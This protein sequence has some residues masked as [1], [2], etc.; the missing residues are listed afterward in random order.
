[1]SKDTVVALRQP[2]GKDLLSAMLREGAQ[3]LIVEALQAEFEEFLSQFAGQRDEHERAAVVRNGFQPRRELLTGLGAVSVRVPKARSRTAESV[4][5]RSTLVPPYVRRAK[6]LDAALPRLYLHGVSTGDMREALASLVG[7]EAKGVSAPVVARLKR[8][9]NQEYQLWRRQKL[10]KDRWVYLWADG[11]YS[12]L[13]AEDERLCALVVIG[14]NER[15]QKHFLAIEDGMR[16]SKTS[17]ADLLRD[18]KRGLEVPP[19]LAVGDGALGFWAALEEIFPQTR[20]QRLLGAQDGERAE[21][22]A[23]VGSGER[24]SGAA[25]DL[26]GRDQSSSRGR[27]RSVCHPLRGQVPEGRRVPGEGSRRAARLL[28]FPSRTLD[29]HPQQQRHRVELRHHSASDQTHQG[30][31]DPRRNAR[32]DLQARLVRRAQLATTA[33][34][35]VAR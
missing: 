23:K 34:I 24:Q 29:P 16:E 4:V 1:M 2:D 20:Q 7:P 13:R 11:I 15:G 14:V 35:R 26:D 18:L 33:R 12:G 27:V 30:L 10:G 17:W 19:K 8:R 3:Q 28:R 25:R 5:F 32:H 22:P 21:L 9:W 6:S 31:F